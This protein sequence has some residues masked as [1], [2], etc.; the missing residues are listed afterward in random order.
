MESLKKY[1]KLPGNSLLESVIALTII[2]VCLYVA[3]LVY[4][5]V[6]SSK[7]TPKFYGTNN[8]LDE[9]FFLMQVQND[10]INYSNEDNLKFE[11][12]IINTNLKKVTIKYKDSVKNTFEKSYYV[13]TINE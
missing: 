11:E 13:Q 1:C 9:L 12:E 2:S 8:K 4:A 7:T 5:S 3:V 10:S 6:F